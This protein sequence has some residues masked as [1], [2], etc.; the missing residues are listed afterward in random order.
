MNTEAT[1]KV[2]I[3]RNEIEDAV[4]RLAGQ[5]KK[6]YRGKPPVLVAVLKG[7]FVFMADLIRR[8]DMPLEVEFVGLSSYGSGTQNC[9]EISVTLELGC[10]ISGRDVIIIED[11]IDSGLTTA[12]LLDYLLER[13][14]ASVKICALTDKPSRRKKEVKIDY[15]GFTVPDRFV[16][17]YGMDCNGKYR[18]LSDI[19]FIEE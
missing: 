6:D 11:I 16:V 9:G 14:P 13:Q 3:K 5:I 15:L 2:L 17:G 1:P 8:L 12:F 10:D 19:C 18:N 4:N 7:A